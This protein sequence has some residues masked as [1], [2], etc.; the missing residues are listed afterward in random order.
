[1]QKEGDNIGTLD[2]LRALG[3]RIAIDDF[4]TGYSSLS[5]LKAFPITTLKI[6]RSFVRDITSQ[7]NDAAIT[8]AIVAMANSLNLNIIVEGVETEEQLAFLVGLG[9]YKMQG[10][11]FSKPIPEEQLLIW[12]RSGGF[13][14]A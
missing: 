11:H 10:F 2:R 8:R 9:C 5:Y 3:V 6:D 4:G 12:L 13:V 1:M 14:E 7:N